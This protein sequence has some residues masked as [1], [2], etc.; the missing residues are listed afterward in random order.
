AEALGK[1]GVAAGPV[2]DARQQRL[3]C[4][5][6]LGGGRSFFFARKRERAK[7]RR[8]RKR[9]HGARR[10]SHPSGLPCLFPS[11]FRPFALSRRKKSLGGRQQAPGERGSLG[12]GEVGQFDAAANV[13]RGRAGIADQVGGSGHAQQAE[14]QPLE[15]GVLTAAV[16]AL[17]NRGEEFVRG[18]RQAAHR[19]DLVDEDHELRRG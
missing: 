11:R 19:V 8:G 4:S 12:G 6:G 10:L 16:V 3:L 2:E 15:L 7:A 1:V 17:A 14:G 13:E 5:R 9:R 18:E